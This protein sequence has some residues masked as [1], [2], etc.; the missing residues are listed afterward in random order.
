MDLPPF[1]LVR[2]AVQGPGDHFLKIGGAPGHQGYRRFTGTAVF[3]EL[4]ADLPQAHQP[5]VEHHRFRFT[6]Q[7]LPVQIHRAVFAVAGDEAHGLGMVPV[8]QRY[9]G[10]G[11][12]TTG[13]G[14][15]RHH[16]KV[17]A[18]GHDQVDFLSAATEDEGVPAFQPTDLLALFGVVNQQFVDVVL[19]QGVLVTGLAHV[20]QLRIPPGQIHDALSYQTVIED[21]I[22]FLQQAQGAEGQQVRVAGTGPHQVDLATAQAGCIGLLDGFAEHGFGFA[23]LASH[24]LLDQRPFQ[25]LL[26]EQTAGAHVVELVLEGLAK[27]GHQ[28]GQTAPASRQ[29]GLKLTAQ[30]ARQYRRGARGTNTD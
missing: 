11:R 28:V 3:H 9:A 12:T 18:L 15:T 1:D 14:D 16:L 2:Q 8:G 25:G 30:F 29:H 20:D 21:H 7:M 22:G 27:P 26:P 19:W 4:C 23:V 17:D 13:G 10:V 5:H 24:D 6:D